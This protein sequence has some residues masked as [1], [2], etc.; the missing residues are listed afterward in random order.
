MMSNGANM[1][2]CLQRGA[3]FDSSSERMKTSAFF[4]APGVMVGALPF[5]AFSA[6]SGGTGRDP[7]IG[8]YK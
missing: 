7:A 6:F 4:T 2:R 5:R 8:C 1:P 3:L